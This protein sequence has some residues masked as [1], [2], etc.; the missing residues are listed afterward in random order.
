MNL[1]SEHRSLALLGISITG[2]RTFSCEGVEILF[3][4]RGKGCGIV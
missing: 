1:G 3:L 4:S 2:P